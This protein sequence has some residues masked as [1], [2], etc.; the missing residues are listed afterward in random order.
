VA[1][2]VGCAIGALEN[3]AHSSARSV[4]SAGPRREVWNEYAHV[5]GPVVEG[6]QE[7]APV[8]QFVVDG[9]READAVAR[10]F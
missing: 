7:E 8:V 3:A 10:P 5:G 1:P 6:A 2:Q 4:V 9:G